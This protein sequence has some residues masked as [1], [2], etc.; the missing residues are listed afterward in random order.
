[1]YSCSMTISGSFSDL[2]ARRLRELTV[3]F[4]LEISC[5]FAFSP[6]YLVLGPKPTSD[7]VARFEVSLVIYAQLIQH[8]RLGAYACTYDINALISGDTNL[9]S[10]ATQINTNN[11]H[12]VCVVLYFEVDKVRKF[13]VK[14]FE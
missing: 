3:F 10:L 9:G 1:M 6:K 11:G 2:P 13:A 12:F 5:V 7:G 8:V 4:K 14:K